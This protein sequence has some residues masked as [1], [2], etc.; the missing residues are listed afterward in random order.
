M[1]YDSDLRIIMDDFNPCEELL[2][3]IVDHYAA[4]Y[5][6]RIYAE[7]PNVTTTY[8]EGYRK[9]TY[10]DLSNAVN[11]LACF[12]TNTLGPGDG[13]ETLPYVGPNDL[14]Y[15][16]LAVGAMKAGYRVGEKTWTVL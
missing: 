11:G 7:Y 16:A 2:P 9:I 6:D 14:R 5:P 3:T 15:P 12:L 13:T 1:T 4:V 8:E 10:R